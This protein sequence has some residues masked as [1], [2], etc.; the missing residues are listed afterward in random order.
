MD[1]R[2]YHLRHAIFPSSNNL[3][4]VLVQNEEEIYLLPVGLAMVS[5]NRGDNRLWKNFVKP[6]FSSWNIL[7]SVALTKTEFI[8]AIGLVASQSFLIYDCEEIVCLDGEDE[9]FEYMFDETRIS[10]SK[11]LFFLH[12]RMSKN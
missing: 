5:Q 2:I 4:N 12:Q 8:T 10:W 11:A 3:Q 9:M 7:L 6:N 1:Y